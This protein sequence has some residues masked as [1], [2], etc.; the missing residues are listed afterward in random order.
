[1][2]RLGQSSPPTFCC[3][4]HEYV[5]KKKERE[6]IL[7]AP[8]AMAKCCK[9]MHSGIPRAQ[10]FYLHVPHT[11]MVHV[12][13]IHRFDP[14]GHWIRK[15]NV[16]PSAARRC[17]TSQMHPAQMLMA[18]A[19]MLMPVAQIHRATHKTVGR[20]ALLRERTSCA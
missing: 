15:R 12:L 8:Q 19:Q 10:W 2:C 18:V 4:E 14:S 7:E 16:K 13:E 6:V 3:P 9:E 11:A 5:K 1:M 20:A 17:R